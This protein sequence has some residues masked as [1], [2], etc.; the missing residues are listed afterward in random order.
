M[1]VNKYVA[2]ATGLSRRAADRAIEEGRVTI[3]Q[4]LATPGS[5]VLRGAAVTL[6][7]QSIETPTE[8]VTIMLNKPFGYI[9]SRDG[10]GGE[11]VYDL[12]PAEYHQLKSVG[13]LDK[14]SSGLLILTNDG[15]L[16]QRLT[17]PRYA[18]TKVYQL[19]LDKPLAALHQQ[20]VTDHG[21]SLDDGPS[22]LD[23][24]KLDETGR[25]WQVTMREGRNR[26]IRRTFAALGYSVQKLH[27][28]TFGNYDLGDLPVGRT[29]TV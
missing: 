17:H 3:D 26:Q 25:Q 23:L 20:M 11:T 1:R 7:G 4:R 28:I 13:R 12:L 27:R 14:D 19:T 2:L 9:C 21:V 22:Q 10:Q 5:T 29:Q 6:D 24:H 8:T 15:D 16:A 18:K